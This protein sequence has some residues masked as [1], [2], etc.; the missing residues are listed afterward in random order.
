MNM[1]DVQL[2]LPELPYDEWE[3]TKATLHLVTQIMGKVKLAR[4]P[5][6]GHW[7]HATLRVT[8]RGISTHTIPVSGGN[9]ELELDVHDLRMNMVT[10]DGFREGFDLAGKSVADVYKA[11]MALLTKA[12]HPTQILAKPYDNPHSTIPFA[13]DREHNSWD[14]DAI[15]RWWQ[16]ML[17]VHEVFTG[18]AGETFYR[19]S[20]VHLFWH[21]FDF[22][23]TRFSGSGGMSVEDGE[24]RS[25]IEAY[26][27]EVISFGFWPGDP[28]V[29]MPAFY[30]YTAP[31]PTALP[32][33]P[34]RPAQAWWQELPS[35]HMALLKY[36]DVR[37]AAD[38]HA[39]V[40]EFCRSAYEAGC[41]AA[42]W[43]TASDNGTAHTW[44]RLDERFPRTQGRERRLT[45]R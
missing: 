30:S 5:K 7:W 3:D 14:Q 20:P 37:A 40:V 11:T 10:S 42:S 34:L 44:D 22:A 21:S 12:G 41:K 27:H 2:N 19:T 39:A 32:E 36:D 33:A 9:F 4:H 45:E 29:R 24:R 23:V 18:I 31:E 38:P 28:K 13:E 35:S 1:S 16:V 26:S 17:F 43:D 15:K 6:M 25:D 8:P